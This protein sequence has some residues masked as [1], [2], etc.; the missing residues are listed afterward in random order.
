[1]TLVF[2]LGDGRRLEVLSSDHITFTWGNW[3]RDTWGTWDAARRSAN[4]TRQVAQEQKEVQW[5]E[6]LWRLED[7]RE[8]S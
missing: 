8:N 1:M 7:K 3:G 5:L 4:I 6:E 2:I